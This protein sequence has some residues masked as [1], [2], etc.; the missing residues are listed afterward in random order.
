MPIKNPEG[1]ISVA[2]IS[3]STKK[4]I[5]TNS[6][7]AELI[8]K[9]LK[10]IAEKPQEFP[11]DVVRQIPDIIENPTE[12]RKS[13][14]AK[15]GERRY[16]F[17]K[18]DGESLTSVVEVALDKNK[19]TVV[20]VFKSGDKYLE[21]FKPLWKTATLPS[22]THGLNLREPLMPAEGGISALKE[23][24]N[25]TDI[26]DRLGRTPKATMN[27]VKGSDSMG[28]SPEAITVFKPINKNASGRTASLK[29][30]FP[31][32]STPKGDIQLS[33]LSGVRSLNKL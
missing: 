29:K 30:G 3:E 9:S 23:V 18:Q 10:H 12:L 2:K 16:L 4:T 5:D 26:L 8:R 11:E 15:T 28:S 13:Y 33:R 19:N 7:G 17:I 31:S 21:D 27:L 1:R 32:F 22:E 6:D 24:Q 25:P 14:G 20:T